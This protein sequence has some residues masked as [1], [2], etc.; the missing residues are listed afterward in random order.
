MWGLLV[1]AHTLLVRQEK[2]SH[3]LFDL[4]RWKIEEEDVKVVKPKKI[5]NFLKWKNDINN[6]KL[7]E[8]FRKA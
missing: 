3:F 1:V 4:C 8:W 7:L 5:R 2:K 6:N